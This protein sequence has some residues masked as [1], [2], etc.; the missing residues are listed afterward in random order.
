MIPS[1]FNW[2]TV[3]PVPNNILT[4]MNAIPFM[5]PRE[6]IIYSAYNPKTHNQLVSINV[7]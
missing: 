4:F 6:D 3:H 1:N 2:K 7:S 5:E